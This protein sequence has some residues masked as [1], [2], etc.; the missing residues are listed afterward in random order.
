MGPSPSPSVLRQVAA[1][2]PVYLLHLCYGMSGGH[3]A[4]TT[5]Q[6]RGSAFYLISNVLLTAAHR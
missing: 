1:V 3:P 6:V 4:V 5:P 2:C